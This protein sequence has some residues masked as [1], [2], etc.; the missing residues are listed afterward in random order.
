MKI[1]TL[2]RI[3]AFLDSIKRYGLTGKSYIILVL[4]RYIFNKKF[5]SKLSF[6]AFNYF[7]NQK[8]WP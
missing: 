1:G 4:K 5:E 6:L 3:S 2:F 8:I 7:T